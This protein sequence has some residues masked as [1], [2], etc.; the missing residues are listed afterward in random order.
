LLY[1]QAPLAPQKDEGVIPNF[2][3]KRRPEDV[4]NNFDREVFTIERLI[5]KN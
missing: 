2:R 4:G 1:F 5:K 3:V